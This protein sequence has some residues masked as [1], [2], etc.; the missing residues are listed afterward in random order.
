MKIRSEGP[1][2][3]TNQKCLAPPPLLMKNTS[4]PPSDIS[5]VVTMTTRSTNNI[6]PHSNVPE[7]ESGLFC[8]SY[9]GLYDNE[10][11]Q[12]QADSILCCLNPFFYFMK[13]TTFP[14]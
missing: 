1:Y 10:F 9:S 5:Q 3:L 8:W 14:F 4:P 6:A 7:Q 13:M 11:L 12:L 2:Y